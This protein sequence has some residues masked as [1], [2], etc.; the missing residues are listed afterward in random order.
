MKIEIASA[1]IL[2]VLL[3]SI[4]LSALLLL[5]PL[6][7]VAQ[8]PARVRVLFVISL[9]TVL[10]LALQPSLQ[11]MPDTFAELL[12]AAINELLLG[13]ALAFGVFAA[14]GAFMFGGRLLDFQMGFG[15]AAL[16]DPATSN[17]SPLIGTALNMMAVATFFLLNGHHL[18]IRGIAYGL[19]RVPLGASLTTLSIDAMV[20]QFGLMFVYGVAVVA[21]A[22]VALLL[23]DAGMAIAARTM[24]QVNMFIVGLPIKIFVGLLLLALSLNHMGPL[25]ERI[26]ESIFRYWEL[27]FDQAL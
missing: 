11:A 17:Q 8:L 4:R 22:L 5:S 3:L 20:I 14:F 26:F 16:I 24:P 23:V 27:I 21:P 18:L 2:A 6:F 10:T 1:L 9:A 12:L 15:V 19:D 7:S 13:A 25:L